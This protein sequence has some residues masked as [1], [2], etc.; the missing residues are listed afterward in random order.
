MAEMLQASA[1]QRKLALEGQR[2]FAMILMGQSE[3]YAG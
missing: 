2:V 3:L 1:E